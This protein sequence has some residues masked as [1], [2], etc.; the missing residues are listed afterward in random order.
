QVLVLTERLVNRPDADGAIDSEF[1]ELLAGEDAAPLEERRPPRGAQRSDNGDGDDPGG[2][3]PDEELPVEEYELCDVGV[4]AEVGQR[5]SR[6]GGHSHVILQGVAR[7]IVVDLIQQ[8]PYVVARVNRH[9][10][11]PATTSEA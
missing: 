8:D 2:W 9:D 7:G 10:D 4:I 11:P 6:P 1:R 3:V 5:I